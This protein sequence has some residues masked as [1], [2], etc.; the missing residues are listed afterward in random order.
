MREDRGDEFVE[1][2]Q[3]FPVD[4]LELEVHCVVSFT[5]AR[6]REEARHLV[7]EEHKVVEGC[8]EVGCG[9]YRIRSQRLGPVRRMSDCTQDSPSMLSAQSCAK[10]WLYK[11]A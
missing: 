1:R 7:K 11:C 4:K 3:L 9:R 8:V 6:W 2:R 5:S 10:W